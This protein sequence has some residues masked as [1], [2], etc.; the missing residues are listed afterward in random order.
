MNKPSRRWQAL[1]G[2]LIDIYRLARCRMMNPHS[3]LKFLH[4]NV[5]RQRCGA[6]VLIETGTYLGVTAA[7]CAKVFDTVITIELNETL[8][9]QAVRFLAPHR[10]V[11]VIC[12]DA[13]RELPGVFENHEIDRAVV[14]L[15]GHYSGIATS[16]GSVPEP[17]IQE[18]AI[19]R[20]YA[21]KIGAILIDDFRSFG[22]EAGFPKKS[23]LIKAIEDLFPDFTIAVQY[24]QVAVVRSNSTARMARNVSVRLSGRD[25]A[26]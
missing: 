26:S 11:K 24:D 9:R 2:Y 10:N 4:I 21:N 13:V 25:T 20:P 15:D 12:G 7:R 5:L 19:L 17:A 3:Y 23:E 8:A 1:G 18:L 16:C 6:N 22:E 14:F